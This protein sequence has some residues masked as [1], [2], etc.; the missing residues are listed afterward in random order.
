MKYCLSII[1]LLAT[2]GLLAQDGV[3][4]NIEI[5]ADTIYMENAFRVKYAVK[6]GDQNGFNPPEITDFDLL[7][8][9]S[10]SS[11]ISIYNGVQSS[12]YTITYYFRPLKTGTFSIDAFELEVDGKTL[13]SN[14]P[15]IIVVDNP[16]N[17]F[18]D[19]NTGQIEGR[20]LP[21]KKSTKRKRFKI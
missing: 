1:L 15:K 21:K 4:L 17:L 10:R 5:S 16:D 7:Q 20:P 6:N 9:P 14:S 8:G 2:V 19:P 13:K 18:Q 11:S 3:E 12:E